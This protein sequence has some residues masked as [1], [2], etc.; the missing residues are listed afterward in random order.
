[1][2]FRRRGTR[3]PLTG[4]WG[5]WGVLDMIGMLVILALAFAAGFGV[6]Y[7]FVPCK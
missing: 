1:M 2:W 7:Y 4:G 3:D 5:G 6:C